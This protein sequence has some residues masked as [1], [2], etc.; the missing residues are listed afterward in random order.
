MNT[1]S[2]GGTAGQA[3]SDTPRTD[4]V[5]ALRAS[6]PPYSQSVGL[7]RDL[8]RENAKLKAERG[9]LRNALE[10]TIEEAEDNVIGYHESM[11][12]YRQSEH[13]RKDALIAKARAILNATAPEQYAGHH[14]DC[15][16]RKGYGVCN[17][18]AIETANG[19]A[20]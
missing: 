15:V 16:I 19:E 7:C 14:A 17:C 8:E 1:A 20:P 6:Y 18:G 4:E 9:E 10:E 11:R 2:P 3:V 5:V 13:D 12:G